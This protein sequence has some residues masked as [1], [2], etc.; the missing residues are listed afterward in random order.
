M[1]RFKDIVGYEDIKNHFQNAIQSGKLSHAYILEGDSGMGKKLLAGTIA[2]V[3]SC[4][5][6]KKDACDECISC[7]LFDTKNHPD[8]IHVRATKK[9]G[10]GVDD[11]RELINK[12]VG[13]KPYMFKEKIYILHEAEKMTVQAQNALLKTIEEPPS[14]VRFILLAKGV[15]QFLPT[16]LSRCVRIKLKP[17]SD[18]VIRN[19][20]ENRLF[21][22]KKSA[23]LYAT[24]A[25]GNIGRAI[26]L[27]DSEDF[28][29]MREDII[30][31]MS[32]MAKGNKIDA[33]EAVILFD[34]YKDN[35]I[36]FLDMMLTWIRDIMLIK[37]IEKG[38]GLIHQDKKEELVKQKEYISFK[39]I[40]SLVKSIEKILRN[41]KLHINYMLSIEVMI[42][43]AFNQE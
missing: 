2:K 29:D 28:K 19:Y 8:I 37:S 9:T 34:K 26:V 32:I 5:E 7:K 35:Q 16:I 33:L 22:A 10:I 12:D 30:E 6:G 13:I 15:H 3:I 18:E 39:K 27:K 21:I 36:E 4:E 24:F 20:L 11:I 31:F 23:K 25:R 17:Q 38:D 14:Y 41:H 40:S 1:H 42:I 43:K